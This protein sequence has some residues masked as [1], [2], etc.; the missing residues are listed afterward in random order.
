VS[1]SGNFVNAATG[2]NEK[3][4]FVVRDIDDRKRMEDALKESEQQFRSL[5]ENNHA[6]MLLIDP[7]SLDIID[8]NPAALDFYGY[9]QEQIIEMKISDINTLSIDQ[10]KVASA[11]AQAAKQTRFEFQHRL[12]SGAIRDVEVYSGLVKTASNNFLYSIV[13]DITD[14]KLAEAKILENTR[15]L[16]ELNLTKDKLFSVIAH[17]LRNPVGLMLSLIDMFVEEKEGYSEAEKLKMILAMQKTAANTYELLENLLDWSRLQRE[18]IKPVYQKVKIHDQ[19]EKGFSKFES[20]AAKK[21]IQLVNCVAQDAEAKVDTNI[22]DTILRNL[23]SNAI[24]FTNRGG[25]I[26]VVISFTPDNELV[27][28]VR[29]NGVGMSE[30]IVNQLFTLEKEPGRPGTDGEKSTGLGLVICK[31]FLDLINGSITV[32]SKVGQGTTF[33]VSFPQSH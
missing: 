1:V 32:E 14:K 30:Q 25:K 26:E 3:A 20:T 9:S 5:F 33:F 11:K 19:I 7:D 24:K 23:I 16:H 29:D 17:D 8:A 12:A 21:H 28:S 27:L 22:F 4:V 13:H 2:T 18:K 6:V 10:L 15:E 31:D